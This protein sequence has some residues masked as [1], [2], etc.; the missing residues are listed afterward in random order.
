[1]DE[2]RV[3]MISKGRTGGLLLY[4]ALSQLMNHQLI[5]DSVEEEK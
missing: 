4:H 2:S 1:M 5:A 3:L